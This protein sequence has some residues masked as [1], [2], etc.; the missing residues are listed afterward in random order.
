LKNTKCIRC[1]FHRTVFIFREIKLRWAKLLSCHWLALCNNIFIR[2]LIMKFTL[3]LIQSFQQQPKKWICIFVFF[4]GNPSQSKSNI[5]F[6][7]NCLQCQGEA[8]KMLT[9]KKKKEANFEMMFFSSF[10][11]LFGRL[12]IGLSSRRR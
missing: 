9:G 6:E 12:K 5:K 10:E 4:K 3:N 1:S 11:T 7:E 8:S 2:K